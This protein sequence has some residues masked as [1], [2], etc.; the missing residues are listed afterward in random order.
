MQTRP[1]LGREDAIQDT[2]SNPPD[3]GDVTGDAPLASFAEESEIQDIRP[4][5]F[6][7]TL[8]DAN[9]I[10]SITD[11]WQDILKLIADRLGG[12]TAGLLSA[13][14]PSRFENGVLTLEFPGSAKIQ[15]QMCESNGRIEQIQA[16]LS[17]QL[18]T[19]IT[20]S[21]D[22]TD[23]PAEA[24]PAVKHAKTFGQKRNELINDPAVKTVL[25][26]LDAT[27]TGIDED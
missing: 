19:P 7:R 25:L 17:E 24:K 2:N 4:A 18:S 20:L 27:I 1:E 14:A 13:A 12:G 8:H 26:G 3:T 22:L 15:K 16:L 23:A 5:A 6:G 10:Q 21:F 9:D 11:N